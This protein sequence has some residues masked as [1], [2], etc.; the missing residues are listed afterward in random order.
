ST[1]KDGKVAM[2]MDG[3]WN[4]KSY[5]TTVGDIGV[6]KLPTLNGKKTVPFVGARGFMIN[7]SSKMMNESKD[8]IINYAGEFE[9]QLSMFK[10]GGRPPAHV[11]A[12]LE[13]QK[14]DPF[15]KPVVDSVNDGVAMPNVKAMAVVFNYAAG[16][17]DKFKT[18]ETTVENAVKSATKTIRDEISSKQSRYE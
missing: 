6:S 7:N 18:G 1:F 3:P 16:M 10:S 13:S 17:V 5:A 11:K 9:G 2:I 14:L 8:F 15:V 4:I 12:N